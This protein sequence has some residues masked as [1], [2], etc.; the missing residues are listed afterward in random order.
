[1]I[2]SLAHISTLPQPTALTERHRFRQFD[3]II[4]AASDPAVDMHVQLAQS[5]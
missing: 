2:W 1:M 4:F 3:L 5:K